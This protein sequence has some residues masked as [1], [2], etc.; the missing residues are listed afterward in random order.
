MIYFLKKPM[1]FHKRNHLYF[2]GKNHV[3]LPRKK[4][5]C[6][7]FVNKL[8]EYFMYLSFL[9][10]YLFRYQRKGVNELTYVLFEIFLKAAQDTAN[11]Q[12]R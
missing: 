1:N 6:F 12:I 8:N 4:S 7:F 3:F 9:I 5:E 11:F 10:S 2:S